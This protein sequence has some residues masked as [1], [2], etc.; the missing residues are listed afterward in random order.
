MDTNPI[1]KMYVSTKGE[2]TKPKG[3]LGALHAVFG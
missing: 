2:V 3:A 1:T